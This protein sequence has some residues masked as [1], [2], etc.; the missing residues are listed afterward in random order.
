MTCQFFLVVL[1]KTQVSIFY[2]FFTLKKESKSL[3]T[4]KEQYEEKYC[5]FAAIFN[6]IFI[7]Y[8]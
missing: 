5:D 6:D 7:F 4:K 1:Y 3:Y 2:K 8:Y